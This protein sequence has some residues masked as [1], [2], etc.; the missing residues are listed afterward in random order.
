MLYPTQ[1][2]KE[3]ISYI[4]EVCHQKGLSLL[5][6]GS[7]AAETAKEFSDIDI[8]VCGDMEDGDLD[9]IIKGYHELVMTNYT[10]NPK[11]IFILNYK[12]GIS[13]DLDIRQ[14][15]T[16]NELDCGIVLLNFGFSVGDA[17]V[18]KD[19]RSKYL[20]DRPQ[21]YKTIRLI[22]RCCIKYLC[23][24]LKA[25]DG[26]KQEMIHSV[27]QCCKKTP[28]YKNEMKLDLMVA[29]QAI[30]DEFPVDR[31]V[32]ALFENLFHAMN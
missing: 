6:E 12:N 7:L 29:F 19:I 16:Q 27:Y 2:H 3:Y 20:P 30:C 21:W 9:D 1:K 13:V 5:L 11:G 4:S 24:N 23:G 32:V 10:E 26:L 25:A 14:T 17:A 18:R 31:E 22:H 15:V 8:V 28:L